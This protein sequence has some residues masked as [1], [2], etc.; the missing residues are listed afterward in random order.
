M[1]DLMSDISSE[2][3]NADAKSKLLASL[4]AK[5]PKLTLAVVDNLNKIK[6]AKERLLN[7]TTISWNSLP[8]DLESR[9]RAFF[10]FNTLPKMPLYE[11]YLKNILTNNLIKSPLYTGI[12]NKLS[13]EYN[14]KDLILDNW[15]VSDIDGTDIT[16]LNLR[17]GVL[18]NFNY[19][20]HP[21]TTIE[22]GIREILDCINMITDN[23][24]LDIY[25]NYANTLSDEYMSLLEIEVFEKMIDGMGSLYIEL[26]DLIA[27]LTDYID[28]HG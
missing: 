4:V 5:G 17:N 22:F 13:I 19:K 20:G 23:I 27:T 7:T 21:S 14:N 2:D 25:A 9:S 11:V 10:N 26:T 18:A 15:Y 8:A 28:Y 24:H 3:I 16:L 12:I 1:N 6:K